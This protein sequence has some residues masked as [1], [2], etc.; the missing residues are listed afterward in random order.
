M[1]QDCIYLILT[2]IVIDRSVIAGT[3]KPTSTQWELS[4]DNVEI[5]SI[6]NANEFFGEC[7]KAAKLTGEND[8]FM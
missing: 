1:L 3:G 7:I 4:N 8:I 5:M 6:K 2:T